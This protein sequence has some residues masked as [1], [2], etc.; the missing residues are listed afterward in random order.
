[1]DSELKVVAEN[2]GYEVVGASAL[3]LS[4]LNRMGAWNPKDDSGDA[5]D[6]AMDMCFSIELGFKEVVITSRSGTNTTTTSGWSRVVRSSVLLFLSLMA[7]VRSSMRT[8]KRML[9]EG[10]EQKRVPMFIARH[11]ALRCRTA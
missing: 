7:V 5:F 11:A 2:L 1:M 8:W 10:M 6:L 9:A 4:L 3:G